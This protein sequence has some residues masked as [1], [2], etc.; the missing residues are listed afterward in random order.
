MKKQNILFI[1]T[2]MFLFASV[3]DGGSTKGK[4]LPVTAVKNDILKDTI[5]DT[6]AVLQEPPLLT[7][8]PRILYGGWR[9]RDTLGH[10]VSFTFTETAAGEAAIFHVAVQVGKRS[11]TGVCSDWENNMCNLTLETKD[12]QNIRARWSFKYDGT[13]LIIQILD[14]QRIAGSNIFRLKKAGSR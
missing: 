10:E 1:C 14:N 8:S 2:A 3:I 11:V 4:N 6:A 5:R 9:G 13:W 12:L 7:V